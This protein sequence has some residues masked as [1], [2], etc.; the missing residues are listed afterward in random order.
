MKCY[1]IAFKWYFYL[2]TAVF[3]LD[4]CVCFWYPESHLL[5]RYRHFNSQSRSIFRMRL[6]WDKEHF[7]QTLKNTFFFLS[8]K[9]ISDETEYRMA[10]PLDMCTVSWW[11]I[12]YFSFC[13]C[14]TKFFI[15]QK[16][17]PLKWS[18]RLAK[19]CRERSKIYFKFKTKINKK[20]SFTGKS[21][22][23]M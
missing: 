8:K 15:W 7:M 16:S 2:D 17:Q 23:K 9:K 13:I 4:M 18:L 3:A 21:G 22:K 10:N 19:R 1:G 11:W 14:N 12:W 20:K 6:R 5:K